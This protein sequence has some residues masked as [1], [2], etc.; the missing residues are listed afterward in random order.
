MPNGSYEGI[1]C[2]SLKTNLSMVGNTL[3]QDGKA[4][5]QDMSAAAVGDEDAPEHLF[6]RWL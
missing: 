6:L 2:D 4:K 3:V 5:R 1:F